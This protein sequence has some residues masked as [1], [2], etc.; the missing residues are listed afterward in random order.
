VISGFS[1]D[2]HIRTHYQSSA[3]SECW[4]VG[5]YGGHWA[6]FSEVSLPL[7]QIS[8][9]ASASQTF[10]N[11]NMSSEFTKTTE[12]RAYVCI[13]CLCAKLRRGHELVRQCY[14]NKNWADLVW[15]RRLSEVWKT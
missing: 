14:M 1:I 8:S 2:I 15:N 5:P 10:T 4:L 9:Y 13:I 12:V 7:D 11:L 3:F 6:P